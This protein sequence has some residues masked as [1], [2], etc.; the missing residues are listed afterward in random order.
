MTKPIPEGMHTV[1]PGL[2]LKG[3]AEALEFYRKA[4]GAIEISRAADPSGKKIWHAAFKIGDST[5]FASDEFPEMGGSGASTAS[6][7]IYGAD[8]DARFKR[9]VD[10]GAKPAMLPTDM[11]WGD[12]FAKV[13]DAWGIEWSL[14]Q[15]MRDLSPAELETAQDAAVAEMNKKR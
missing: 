3:C 7:W 11:F 15:R 2:T 9:A 14:A 6:L 8:I 13:V 10:A 4:F 5:I 12:R 1:T